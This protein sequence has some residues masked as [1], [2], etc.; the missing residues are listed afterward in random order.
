MRDPHG[1]VSIALVNLHLQSRFRMPGVNADDGQPH[2]IQL[3]PQPRR[4]CSRLE[5]NPDDMWCVQFDECRDRLRVGCN[6]TFAL[7]LPCPIDDA[8]RSQFQRH[9]QSDIVLHCVSPFLQGP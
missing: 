9:V 2:L 5:P 3:G 7:D 1:V 8:D 4:R 6:H